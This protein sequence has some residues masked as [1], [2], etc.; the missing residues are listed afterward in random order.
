MKKLFTLIVIMFTLGNL[1]S[2]ALADA[3]SDAQDVINQLAEDVEAID[4]AYANQIDVVDAVHSRCDSLYGKNGM[5]YNA[6]KITED[7]YRANKALIKGAYSAYDNT[8]V[9]AMINAQTDVEKSN[10]Y[11]SSANSKFATGDYVGASDDADWGLT[12]VTVTNAM[13]IQSQSGV[14]AMNESL[15]QV[16]LP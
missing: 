10:A 3:E 6:N 8:I 12:W 1:N 5:Y 14:D 9:P 16:V 13:L 11:L 4:E 7:A 2:V 15:N